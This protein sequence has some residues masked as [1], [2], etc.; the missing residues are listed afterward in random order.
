MKHL[1]NGV[2][3]ACEDEDPFLARALAHAADACESA[4]ARAAAAPATPVRSRTTWVKTHDTCEPEKARAAAGESAAARHADASA[5][6][7]CRV[8]EGARAAAGEPAATPARSFALSLSCVDNC[9]HE[10]ATLRR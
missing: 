3:G 6:F 10:P 9:G 5:H 8:S 1:L 2:K 4:L 7:C